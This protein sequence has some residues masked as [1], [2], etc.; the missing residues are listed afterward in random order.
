MNLIGTTHPTLTQAGQL[1]RAGLL[2]GL[3]LLL[4]QAVAGSTWSPTSAPSALWVSVASSSDGTKL[5]AAV[6]YVG[7]YTSANSGSTWSPTSAPMEDWSSVASSSDGTKLVA[8]ANGGGIYTNSGSTW[9]PTSAL[10]EEWQSVASSS[11]GT[12]LVAVNGY[13][14]IYTS[15]NSGSTW[16]PTSAPSTNWTSVASSSDGTKLVAVVGGG[17]GIYTLNLPPPPPTV[18]VLVYYPF[19]TNGIPGSGTAAFTNNYL[20]TATI[21]PSLST[22]TNYNKG[23]ALTF[24]MGTNMSAVGGAPAGDAVDDGNWVGN[25]NYYQFTFNATGYQGIIVNYDL[26]RSNTGPVTNQFQYS[27]DGGT[28]FT[29][30]ANNF[31][32]QSNSVFMSFTND[33]SGATALTN[34]PNVVFRIVGTGNTGPSGAMRVDNFTISGAVLPD[35]DIGLRVFDGNGIVKIGAQSGTPTSAFRINKNGTNYG[36]VL[37]ATNSASASRVRIQTSEGTRSLEKLP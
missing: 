13:G 23:T 8:V 17:G 29:V 19:N 21:G 3:A 12:K 1:L 37:V 33:V 7:I 18:S 27:A 5:V 31:N 15:A 2:C 22:F 9:S 28:T 16:S 6:P 25:T 36:I 14:G 20:E 35:I 32:A 24:V 34:N 4:V 10:S 26:A 11:D 30:F